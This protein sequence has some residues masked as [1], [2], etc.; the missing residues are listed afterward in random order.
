MLILFTVLMNSHRTTALEP[1][2]RRRRRWRRSLNWSF[3]RSTSSCFWTETRWVGFDM[4]DK[5]LILEKTSNAQ[6]WFF[7]LQVFVW[8]YDPVHFKTFAM[9]LILGGSE[10]KESWPA[11]SVLVKKSPFVGDCSWFDFV[12]FRSVSHCSDR[13][14]T[15]PTVASR[16]ACR[17]LLSECCGRLLCGQYI[18]SCCR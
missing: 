12:C 8:I 7:F 18:A 11:W 1:P 5:C 6:M 9:G 15:L 10:V 17:S 16:N 13:S 2:R 3:M 14:H 4:W